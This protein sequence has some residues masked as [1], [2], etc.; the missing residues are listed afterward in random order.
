MIFVSLVFLPGKL[1]SEGVGPTSDWLDR[2]PV[3]VGP[4]V[5]SVDFIPTLTNYRHR[6]KSQLDKIPMTKRVKGQ[7]ERE[8]VTG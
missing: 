7:V 6:R 5:N 8:A 1:H 3:V 2:L 4:W